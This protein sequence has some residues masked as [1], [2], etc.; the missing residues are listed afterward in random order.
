VRLL[1]GMLALLGGLL[2]V[3][4]AVLVASLAVTVWAIFDACRRPEAAWRRIGQSRL[5]WVGVLLA[6][7]LVTGVAGLVLA[8][9]YLGAVRPRLLAAERDQPQPR[10]S[11]P[12]EHVR[13]ALRVSDADR[14]RAG[15]W[16]QHH[17]TVGRLTHDELLQRLDEALTARTVA[18]LERSLRELPQW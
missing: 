4:V 13:R 8:L 16:L 15:A 7:W 11:L 6:G 17:Y 1:S 18:D 2:L 10:R 9:L 5:C 12:P 14:D 3:G